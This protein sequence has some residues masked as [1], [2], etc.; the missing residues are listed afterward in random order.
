MN[1]C[2]TDIDSLIDPSNQFQAYTTLWLQTVGVNLTIFFEIIT[3]VGI[4]CS[5]CA[6]LTS[7][8]RMVRHSTQS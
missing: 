6:N 3:F 1:Y 2:I 8:S 7:A 5:N 4:E